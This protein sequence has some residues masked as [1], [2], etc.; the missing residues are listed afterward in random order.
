MAAASPSRS[1]GLSG[2][3]ITSLSGH[4][5]VLGELIH[6]KVRYLHGRTPDNQFV[7]GPNKVTSFYSCSTPGNPNQ[8]ECKAVPKIFFGEENIRL[9]RE[10]EILAELCDPNIL[11][12]QHDNILQVFDIA[13]DDHFVFFFTHYIEEDLFSVIYKRPAFTEDDA[14]NIVRQILN[15]VAYLHRRGICHR[16]LKP[17]NLLC[18]EDGDHLLVVVTGFE[19]AKC[20][21]NKTDPLKSILGSGRYMAPEVFQSRGY[22]YTEKCDIWSV[23]IIAYVILTKAFPF[24]YKLAHIAYAVN[25]KPYDKVPLGNIS[26]E[27]Q[28]FIDKLLQ[29]DPNNRPSAQELLDSDPWLN[30]SRTTAPPADLSGNRQDLFEVDDDGRYPEEHDDDDDD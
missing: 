18:I 6:Y 20:F 21:R 1:T 25:N 10:A 12:F 8:Y 23:G 9:K 30:A 5:Y 19:L 16:N 22:A 17:E 11:G 26:P 24:Q 7:Q 4:S 15:G 28:A 3:E 29:K 13:E 27:G 14:R 2:Y